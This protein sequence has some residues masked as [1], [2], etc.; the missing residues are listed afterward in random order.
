VSAAAPRALRGA[1]RDW[2]AQHLRLAWG[3]TTI[4]SRGRVRDASALPAIVCTQGEELVGLATY[5][6]EADECELVTIEAFRRGCGVGSALLE[7]VVALAR[8]HT[9]TRVVLVTT[10]DN[11]SAQRFYEHRG[12]RLLAVHRG[13]VD[14]ARKLKPEIPLVGEHSV[15][16]HDELEYELRLAQ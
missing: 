16:I 12:F 11:A 13:A 14:E 4:V 2:L 10:N 7:E 9:C 3:S 1:E 15:E 8:E 6:I 5:A